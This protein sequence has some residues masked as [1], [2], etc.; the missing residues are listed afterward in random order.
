MKKEELP[1]NSR[2]KSIISVNYSQKDGNAGDAKF[3][4]IGYAQWNYNDISAKVFRYNERNNRW[5][6]GS[7]E[8][9]LWRVLDLA[10]LIIETIKGNK[11]NLNSTTNG[12]QED[13]YS[14][15]QYINENI[16][17]YAPRIN[18]LK[19]L[20]SSNDLNEKDSINQPNIF[21]YATSELSQDA[22]LSWIIEWA[23][24]QNKNNDEQL[25]QL[26]VE[27][28]RMLTNNNNLNISSIKIKRQW[29]H[30]DICVEINS[31]TVLII[32]DK[33]FTS[34]HSNQLQ[35]YQ[36]SL[37]KKYPNKINH[38]Y[39]YL[40]TGNEAKAKTK[41][42]KQN[43]FHIVNRKDILRILNLYNGTNCII[44]DYRKYLKSLEEKTDSFNNTPVKLWSNYA[45]QGFYM[46]IEKYIVDLDWNYIN[47]PSGGF[48]GAWWHF[49]ENDEI[50]MY[51]QFEQDK[52]CFKINCKS[53]KGN[54]NYKRIREK[55]YKILH[56][57]SYN[58]P[59]IERPKFSVGA[60]MTISTI[61]ITHFTDTN[62]MLQIS[63]LLKEIG[64]YEKLID[65][66][67]ANSTH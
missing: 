6:R 7:E 26:G 9:P 42:I 31:D 55:Y 23:N 22:I 37:Q 57:Y 47:N 14:L 45:W 24:P 3:L 49:K 41:G 30:I 8:L 28:V 33:T 66:C 32:E 19:R 25:W 63:N 4:S 51:L 43:G 59:S 48:H 58:N 46:Y 10:T 61:K 40:K 11:S 67:I 27:F 29:E 34:E 15:K 36:S 20:L 12:T 13:L 16:K 5:A 64:E 53:C 60:C 35:R 18:E 62:G 1:K 54:E 65:N 39:V 2:H 17:L 44:L 50:K 38:I 52:I 21:H 56:S